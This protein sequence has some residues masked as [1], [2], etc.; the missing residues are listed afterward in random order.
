MPLAAQLVGSASRG[1]PDSWPVDLGKI[2]VGVC[3]SLPAEP[4]IRKRR[5]FLDLDA[6]LLALLHATR[7]AR[8]P[9][10]L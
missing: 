8:R 3:D 4:I 7:T 9:D 2:V 10:R 1:E 6:S 5:Q